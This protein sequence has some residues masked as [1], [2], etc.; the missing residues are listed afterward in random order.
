LPF[1]AAPILFSGLLLLLSPLYEPE[2]RGVSRRTRFAAV[3]WILLGVLLVLPGTV[4]IGAVIKMAIAR[5]QVTVGALFCTFGC[6]SVL[7]K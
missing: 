2:E 4:G 1:L 6:Y 5:E 3:L 7:G